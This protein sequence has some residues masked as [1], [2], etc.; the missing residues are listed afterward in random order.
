MERP[1]WKWLS[2]AAL[3]LGCTAAMA[4]GAAARGTG[5]PFVSSERG[6]VV[7]VLNAADLALVK[8][9]HT[10]KRPQGMAFSPDRT[11]LYVTSGR[12]DRLDVIDVASLA[13]VGAV[14]AGEY[15]EMAAVH[16]S[17]RTAYATNEENAA[18]SV[19]DLT[20][21]RIQAQI[22][23]CAEPEGAAVS[24]DGAR[25]YVA[26]EG[27]NAVAILDAASNRVV[28]QAPVGLKPRRFAISA[29]GGAVW[30]T[31]E[32][33]GAAQLLDPLRG[34][35]LGELRFEPPN[36]RRED[37]RPV[38]IALSRDGRR[39]FVALSRAGVV[40]V[41]DTAARRVTGYWPAGRR[42]MDVV[43]AGGTLFVSDAQDD[44]VLALDAATGRMLRN[45]KVGRTPHTVLVDE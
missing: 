44:T 20:A 9:I 8:V 39:A 10:S 27:A 16:P 7:T 32:A 22:R 42:P 43:F 45:A 34:T 21:G 38:G 2:G 28:T 33:A 11:R 5:Y 12:D 25:V 19:I 36:V 15:P 3:A 41:V 4:G 30:L 35:V 37:I 26:C 1:V 31:A 13:M 24:P 40:A 14:P 17:G 29:D 6:D 23:T 18:V